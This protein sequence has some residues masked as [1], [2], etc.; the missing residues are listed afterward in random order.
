MLSSCAA[1]RT[2]KPIDSTKKKFQKFESSK[3][4][5]ERVVGGGLEVKVLI[6]TCLLFKYILSRHID[7]LKVGGFFNIHIQK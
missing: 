5:F 7:T 4:T 3:E 2:L 6:S 1:L